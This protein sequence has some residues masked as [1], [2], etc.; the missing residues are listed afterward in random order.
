M[1]TAD[2]TSS[3]D[4]SAVVVLVDCAGGRE[5]AVVHDVLVHALDTPAVLIDPASTAISLDVDTGLLTVDG[6]AVRPA[7]TWIRHSS[8]YALKA[9][10][11]AAGAGPRGR[12]GGSA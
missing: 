2:R 7:V 4:D 9:L 10:D 1:A 12:G 3:H 5:L 6:R 8:V 11:P